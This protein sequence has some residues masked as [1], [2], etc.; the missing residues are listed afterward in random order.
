MNLQLGNAY[1]ED[2][3]YMGAKAGPAINGVANFYSDEHVGYKGNDDTAAG[4]APS[5]T[6]VLPGGS[7]DSAWSVALLDDDDLVVNG[8]A[9]RITIKTTDSDRLDGAQRAALEA[10]GWSV[11]TQ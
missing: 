11:V 4:S 8:A 9:R 6:V 5:G 10:G 1:H 3:P 7:G 2:V